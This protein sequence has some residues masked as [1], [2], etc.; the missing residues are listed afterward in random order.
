MSENDNA[1]S[2]WEKLSRCIHEKALHVFGKKTRTSEDWYEANTVRMDPLVEVKRRT[3]LAYKQIPNQATLSSLKSARQ[4]CRDMARKCANEYWNDLCSEIELAASN[5]DLRTMYDGIRKSTGPVSS[6]SAPLKSKEGTIIIEKDKQMDRWVEHY[7]DLYSTTNS[8]SENAVNN[9]PSL[10]EMMELDTEPS[11]EELKEA[12][13]ALK[14]GKAPGSDGIP[15]ELIKNAQSSLLQPIYGLLLRCWYEGEVPRAMRDAK[16]ITLYKNKGDRSDCNNYRGISLLSIVGKIFARVLLPRL[17]TVANRVY[18]EAQ[19]GFRAGRSTIDM[20]FSIRQLQEKCREQRRPLYI[21]FVDLTKAFDLV[22]RSGLFTL[23]MKIGC[24]PK[25][26]SLIISF[27]IRMHGTVSFNGEIS[28]P[29]EIRS[30][31]KQGCVLAPTL[32]GVFFSLLLH[33]AFR[34][35]REGVLLHTRHD[36]KLFNLARLRAKTKVKTVLI[37]EMLFADDAAFV[38]H[39]EEGLQALMDNFSSACEDFGLTIS[40]KK[41]EVLAQGTQADPTIRIRDQVLNNV[42]SF[43][44]LGST[45]SSN[46]SLDAELN[47]R[48]GK[49]AAVFGKLEKRVWS[50]HKLRLK[51]KARVYTACVLSTLLYGSEAWPSYAKEESRLNSFHLRCLR[52]ILGIT[53]KDEVANAEVLSRAGVPTIQSLLSQ[54]RLRWLGHVKRM[55]PERLPK[56]LLYGQLAAGSR[57]T[58]RPYLRYKDACKRDLKGAAISLEQWEHL[59]EDRKA[60]R[61]A[62]KHG[63]THAEEQRFKL[64]EEKRQRRKASQSQTQP[65][66][67]VL[68]NLSSNGPFNNPS[69]FICPKCSRLCRSRIGFYSHTKKCLTN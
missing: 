57:P 13:K 46:L 40:I 30:G 14:S 38:S 19:C 68:N 50:N 2:C 54:R 16:I 65:D 52:K 5:G 12:I 27:H 24:P 39:T 48:I 7:L 25:L 32:F 55:G 18:P 49:A 10:P 66:N 11:I 15:P 6:K 59:A 33:H 17:Q 3:L 53:W 8:V 1:A 34:S 35:S 44:Y 69:D 64:M 31:V 4:Q 63:C 51:T 21:A 29:F 9:I 60:W 43:K 20:V 42:S 45:I 41:T 62:V 67:H 37:R 22:S 47:S 36:G 61:S 26:L 58:G 56:D 23:L 28:R